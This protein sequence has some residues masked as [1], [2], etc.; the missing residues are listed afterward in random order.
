MTRTRVNGSPSLDSVSGW[1]GTELCPNWT[2][3]LSPR[4]K[5][6]IHKNVSLWSRKSNIVLLWGYHTIRISYQWHTQWHRVQ[7][8]LPRCLPH[9]VLNYRLL[10]G[11]RLTKLQVGAS[12]KKVRAV[13]RNAL[14]T[15]LQM[16][17]NKSL[18]GFCQLKHTGA[19][20]LKWIQEASQ[21]SAVRLTEQMRLIRR[22]LSCCSF[23]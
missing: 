20:T 13:F 18:A 6:I 5:S 3:V 11:N 1:P 22:T 9:R 15:S 17:H 2:G 14:G 7:T 19:F 12:W 4:H 23:T 10:S 21:H 16:L 8:T